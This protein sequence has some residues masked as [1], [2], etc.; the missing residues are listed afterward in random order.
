VANE[1]PKEKR[2][3]FLRY[4][5]HNV[6]NY[7]LLGGVAATAVL[8]QNWWLGLAGAAV[9]GL[10]LMF[11]PDSRLLGKLVWD[12]RFAAQEKQ[13]KAAQRQ[14][15]MQILSPG[16]WKRCHALEKKRLEI[17]RL[18]D[19]NPT[20]TRE[21]LQSELGKLEQLEDAYVDMHLTCARFEQY[22]A[23]VDFDELE[24]AIRRFQSQIEK[25]QKSTEDRLL[26]Q[27]NLEVVLQRKERLA[28]IQS[29]VRKAHGQLDLIEN[30][31]KLLADQIVTMR[32]PA[33]LGGQLDELMDG[34]EAVRTTARETEGMMQGAER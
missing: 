14:K 10:W 6:Y 1:K 31:F 33:E 3:A 5:F 16:D 22:L 13:R 11:A 4:A 26:A 34:V 24:R 15:E 8:T 18:C 12:Q 21:L 7:T 25:S 32:S 30:T 19:D 29:Y 20:F 17:E 27:K 2:G 9:E 23:S 28:E